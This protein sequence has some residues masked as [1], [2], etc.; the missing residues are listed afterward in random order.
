MFLWILEQY[1][2]QDH[3]KELALYLWMQ[4]TS[5]LDYRIIPQHDAGITWMMVMV[6]EIFVAE[7]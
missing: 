6:V 1:V 5:I 4:Y 2:V 7:F 3:C